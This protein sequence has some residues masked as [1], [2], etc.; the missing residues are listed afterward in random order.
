MESVG[1]LHENEQGHSALRFDLA[2]IREESRGAQARGFC[3]A[4][5]T[6]SN[7]YI[8]FLNRLT[9]LIVSGIVPHGLCVAANPRRDAQRH[10]CYTRRRRRHCVLSTI[11][12]SLPP[13]TLPDLRGPSRFFRSSIRGEKGSGRVSNRIGQG[14][15]SLSSRGLLPSERSTVGC[16]CAVTRTVL[17]WTLNF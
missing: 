5:P 9:Y 6:H 16:R 7:V 3:E 14:G 1:T 15:L 2:A 12:A 4:S 13:R 17:R 8:T 10:R 11:D